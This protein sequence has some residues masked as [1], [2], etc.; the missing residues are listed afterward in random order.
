MLAGIAAF[1]SAR[2]T[3]SL[4]GFGDLVSGLLR[5]FKRVVPVGGFAALLVV[6]GAPA[7]AQVNLPDMSDSARS[8]FNAADDRRLGEAF[9]R[10]VRASAD[11]LDDP[12]IER[13]IQSLGYT[14]TAKSASAASNF[15]FFVV[16]ERG[17]NAFA[18]PGGYIGVNTGLIL[19]SDTES[20]LASVMAHEIAHVTQRHIA[21]AIELAGQQSIPVM[22]GI[23]A[24][25]ILGLANPDAGRAT[26]VAVQGASIQKQLDFTRGNEL[27][28]DREG[29]KLLAGAGF[30]PNAMPSF[31]EKLQT[32]TRYS[33]RPPEYL[34]TH[35]V[36]SARIADTRG[37]AGRYPYRQ[38]P[39]SAEFHVVRN[40]AAVLTTKDL[41]K[42]TA[43]LANRLESGRYKSLSATAYGWGLALLL[44]GKSEQ[45][46][47]ILA[48]LARNHPEQ[49]AFVAAHGE[50]AL[51]TGDLSGALTIYADSV[52]LYPDDPV[53]VVG[54]LRALLR[55]K[56]GHAARRVIA[57]FRRH[58]AMNAAMYKL[59]AQASQLE[60]LQVESQLALAEHF[61]LSGNLPAALHQLRRANKNRD[62]DFYASS[63]AAARLRELEREQELRDRTN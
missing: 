1:W 4:R 63:R 58:H 37:R 35:P 2:Y 36:T 61:Y 43:E 45:A 14:L 7:P 23:L 44:Q 18:G 53:L 47:E 32:A 30:D 49:T 28:A 52:S 54:Y 20:E 56:Q 25:V 50:A 29:M 62:G 10:A 21:R 9:I 26:L 48:K 46:L 8:G 15:H 57:D 60:G 42:L 55:A 6:A 40:R 34:S 22:A 3:N 27:E 12:V 11:V 41:P 13:Y 39:D 59:E 5:R 51:A 38:R 31:F 24:G 19:S 16:K 17:I 33:R